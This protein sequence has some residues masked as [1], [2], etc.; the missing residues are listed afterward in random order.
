MFS[1]WHTG[2]IGLAEIV[3]REG[4]WLPFYQATLIH[5]YISISLCERAGS[6]SAKKQLVLLALEVN[7]P[8]LSN[9]FSKSGEDEGERNKSKREETK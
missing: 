3:I 5:W 1:S 6:P 2:I 9:L 7:R 4:A 8:L